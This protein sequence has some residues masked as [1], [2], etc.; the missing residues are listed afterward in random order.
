[1]DRRRALAGLAALS[2]AGCLRLTDDGGT[3]TAASSGGSESTPTD[4][5]GG[6]AS[7]DGE[8]PSNADS[9]PNANEESDTPASGGPDADIW[10]TPEGDGGD[11]SR[12]APFT[13][14]RRALDVADP[15]DTVYLQS[16]EYRLNGK[17]RA[18]GEP[19]SPIEI[20][21]P[22]DAVVRARDGNAGAVLNIIHSHVHVTGLT[23]D[24][25]ADPDRKWEDPDAWVST[26]VHITPGPR[27]ESEGVGYLEDVVFEPHAVRNSGSEFVNVERTRDAVLGDFTVTGPAGGEFHP[28]MS[29]PVES[30]VGNVFDVGTTPPTVEEYKPWDDLDRTRNVRIHHVDNSAGYHHSNFFVCY[31]GTEEI[32]VEYCTDRN[33]G[34]E[35]SGKDKVSALAIGGNNCTVRGND[36][37]DCRQGVG[38]SGWA[39][40]DMADPTNWARNNDVYT[41]RFQRISRDVFWFADTTPEA[42]RTLCDNRFVGIDETNYEYATGG[43]PDDVSAVEGIGHTAGQ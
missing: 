34:N 12:E 2:T 28:E 37:G 36:I 4:G 6:A 40:N 26:L 25:L 3:E 13:N 27:F 43:C 19:G 15:G 11:G 7:E 17:T 14:V 1:M 10:V 20:T 35:T 22:P 30:H 9:E 16:G 32:T 21:G 29:N 38:V 24:G 39:P 31:V 23:F 33:A 42:Q 8:S 5:G 18:A 41:N